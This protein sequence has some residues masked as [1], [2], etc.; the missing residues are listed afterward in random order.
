MLTFLTLLLGIVAGP[1][2]VELGV[3]DGTA[4]VEVLLDGE[5]VGLLR[6]AP[7]ILVVDFGAVPAPHHLDAVARD[8][9]GSAIGRAR[10]RVNVPRLE[11]E[12][13]L[14]LV[15]GR[16]GTGRVARLAWEGAVGAVPR[17][18]TVRFDGRPLA[19]PDPARIELPPFVPER[20]HFLHAAVE[21]D[22]G[23][24]AEAE[25]T[26]GGRDR[27]ET[28]RELAAIPMRALGGKLP[29]P[30]AMAD[31]LAADG[32][33]LRVVGSEKGEGSIVFVL[34]ADG[35]AAFRQM[36]DSSIFPSKAG[37]FRGEPEVR[38]LLAYCAEERGAQAAYDVFPRSFPAYLRNGSSTRSRRSTSR[39]TGW[40]VPAS[41]TPRRLPASSPP[42][43]RI[44]VWS[45]WS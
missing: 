15:P 24:R 7:W 14:A 32:A 35:P 36:R 10:Q 38:M 1:R 27:D 22:R 2:E 17:E 6:A 30:D 11:V 19:A 8:A 43:G 41:R 29:S 31:W 12:A 39:G 40:R 3:P 18:V 33:P 21:F 45:S 23:A 34:D 5:R 4:A 44:P 25:I 28:S 37:V 26:F 42:P 20:L 13:V 16:G 9:D